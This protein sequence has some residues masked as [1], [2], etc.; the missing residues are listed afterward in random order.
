MNRSD[1]LVCN[2][3]VCWVA[4]ERIMTAQ[5]QLHAPAPHTCPT[6]RTRSLARSLQTKRFTQDGLLACLCIRMCADLNMYVRSVQQSRFYIQ[7]IKMSL[8]PD[9]VLVI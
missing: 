2:C 5:G 1:S 6:A 3:D 7:D 4:G 8:W 9:G